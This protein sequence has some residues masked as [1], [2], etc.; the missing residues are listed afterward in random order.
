VLIAQ[1]QP[2]IYWLGSDILT[3]EALLPGYKKVSQPMAGNRDDHKE[4]FQKSSD[5]ITKEIENFTFFFHMK[6][7]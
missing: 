5:I 7:S 1:I 6:F 3:K 2:T 4:Q